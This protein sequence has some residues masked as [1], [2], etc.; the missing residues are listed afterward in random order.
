MVF[1]WQVGL[2]LHPVFHSLCRDVKWKADEWILWVWE[3]QWQWK[4]TNTFEIKG[5]R[6]FLFVV[7]LHAVFQKRRYIKSRV[8][9]SFEDLKQSQATLE[10]LQVHGCQSFLS[11]VFASS[12]SEMALSNSDWNQFRQHTVEYDKCMESKKVRQRFLFSSFVFAWNLLQID[13]NIHW[14]ITET[15]DKLKRYAD[16]FLF[17]CLYSHQIF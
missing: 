6:L 15:L 9:W 3:H 13:L 17:V 8:K 12:L 11:F 5:M 1:F 7:Y 14:K 4:T 2:C 16:V 10:I